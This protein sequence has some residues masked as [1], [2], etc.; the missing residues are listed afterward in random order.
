[1]NLSQITSKLSPK[2]W[3]MVGGSALA[4]IAFLY[5]L[6]TMAS[7]P[8]YTTIM[9]G[10]P[11]AN[12][13]KVETTLAGAGVSYQLESNGTAV[14]VASAQVGQAQAA[15]ATAGLLTNSSA[16]SACMSQMSNGSSLGQSNFQQSVAYQTCLEQQLNSA[17][18]SIQ[19]ISSANVQL[20][21]PSQTDQLFGST[22]SPSA[23]VLISDS[24]ML[25]AGAVRGIADLVAHAVTGLSPDNVTITDENGQLLWPSSADGEGG[26]L[27]SKQSAEASYDASV[28]N[29]VNANLVGLFGAGAAL[30][31]V[32]ADLDANQVTEQSLAYSK[33]CVPQTQ[34]LTTETLTGAT[35]SSTTNGTPS[36]TAGTTGN[37]NYKS[38][39]SSV[40][41]ACGKRVTTNVIAPGA[42]NRQT[43]SVLVSSK[44]PAAT[45]TAIKQYV[46]GAV[47][48]NTKRGDT[49]TV[50]QAAFKATPAV[51]AAAAPSPMMSYAKYGLIGLGTLL[52][53]F[54][55]SRS[56]KRR[57]N[58]AFQGV[59]T[60]LRE[61]EAPRSLAELEAGVD[62]NGEPSGKF[63]QLH[64]P[65]NVARQQVDDL[66][67]RD[68]E[69]VAAEVRRWYNED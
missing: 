41:S 26:G 20:A 54:F 31:S 22:A 33:T 23:S 24:G 42:I 37:S 14:A 25:G 43:V 65:I 15:L 5:I 68:P 52:F 62:L 64:S 55:M 1:M 32:N 56:L 2:G 40:S 6:T 13:N 7:A 51:A 49:L 12:T 30:V 28:A 53:L 18:A 45:V 69:R 27:L 34:T 66:V 59:P 67:D 9:A 8:S 50:G 10:I 58:E 63:K 44:L 57:E 36:Y 11:L 17:I 21:I 4:T 19:G 47:G 60:W 61:L 29:H 46:A 48:I 39:S 35:P 3:L 38:R 16:S